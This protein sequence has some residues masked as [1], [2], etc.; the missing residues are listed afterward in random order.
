MKDPRD[1]ILLPLI[2]EKAV[3]LKEKENAYVFQVAKGANKIE[4]KK[5]IQELFKVN[6]INITTQLVKGKKRRYG[7]FEGKRPD[8]KKA[9]CKLKEGDRI[10]VFEG[11]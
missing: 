8:W 1:I 6:V 9:I 7:R 3:S 10:E 11:V 5:A 2:T 4:I